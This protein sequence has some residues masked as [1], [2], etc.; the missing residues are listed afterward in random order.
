MVHYYYAVATANIVSMSHSNSSSV[1]EGE[2]AAAFHIQA[3]QSMDLAAVLQ[4]CCGNRRS[5]QITFRS[6]E[7]YGFVYIQHG[8]VLH[9]MCGMMEGEDAIYRMLS[10]PQGVFS[11]DQDILPHKKTVTLTWEQLLFEGARRA[12]DADQG[13]SNVLTTPVVTAEPVTSTRS[14]DS[15]PKLTLILPDQSP[16]TYELEA[17]YTHVGR[18]SGNEVPLPYGSVSN[19]HCIFILSGADVLLRDLNSS[20]GT[21]V[22]GQSISETILRPGDLIQVGVVQIKFEPG[23]RRPKLTQTSPTGYGAGSDLREVSTSGG[24]PSR[25]TVKLPNRSSLPSGGV[26]DDS[27][28]VKGESPISYENLAKPEQPS[29]TKPMLLMIVGGVI[30]VLA[31]LGGG[32]YYFVILHR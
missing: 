22:N 21:V 5:G 29:N 28:F 27:A 10:W 25:T 1:P 24:L 15:L 17:E 32:Y 9:A 4:L 16:L 12:D 30:V 31:L 7:S 19:R 13:A 23:V 8:H 20:N 18:A 14:K 2:N 3:S 11:L 6:G 26:K